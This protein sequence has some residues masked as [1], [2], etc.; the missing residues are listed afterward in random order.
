MLTVTCYDTLV[1]IDR[2]T[3]QPS[4]II[5]T[6]QH[7]MIGVSVSIIIPAYNSK[8]TI[9]RCLA[10]LEEQKYSDNL[11]EI[12]VVDSSSDG[13]ERLIAD[14][15]PWV[16]LYHFEHRLYPGNARNYGV[17]NSTGDILVFL[18]ADCWVE[19]LWI[20]RIV[21]AH[22]NN[23]QLAIGG[24][25]ANGNPESYVGWG[26]YFSGLSSFMPKT[27]AEER[28]DLPTGCLSCRRWVFEQYGPFLENS[29]CEDTL[30]TWK[31]QEAG[32]SGLFEPVIQVFHI[33]IEN[34]SDLVR[35]KIKHGKTF[36]QLRVV[37][38]NLP[39]AKQLLYVIASF[40]LPF[41][42]TYRRI[43]DV[44]RAKC[45]QKQF[46]LTL[47]I[48]FISLSCWSLGELWGY[49]N[50]LFQLKEQKEKSTVQKK[51]SEDL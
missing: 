38:Q 30:F 24:A 9:T 4:T 40:I 26:Y 34:F 11:F 19:P 10:S 22:Q 48:T 28:N 20:Q 17:A 47:P 3:C 45:Y 15:F 6:F 32:H 27:A 21:E 13:T 12:I 29:L 43:K 36:A 50:T 16:V 8:K 25:I 37:E 49:I 23:S 46:I 39:K 1:C 42:L 44:W 5:Y 41:L 14:E 18:D 7:D 33:N 31:L 51:G 35:R 2:E